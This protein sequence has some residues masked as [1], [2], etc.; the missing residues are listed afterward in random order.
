MRS[1][2]LK[3]YQK[4]ES[5]GLWREAPELQRREVVVAF[6]EASLTLSDP[7]TDSAL[8]HWSL[9]AVER[10]NPGETPALYSP[11]RDALET[12]ELDSSV[13]EAKVDKRELD[14]AKRL[15][16]D[17][18][19]QWKPADYHDAF[20]QTIMDLVEEKASKG[21]IETVE[22]GEAT[23]AGKGADIL[24]LTELL[25]RSLGGKKPAKKTRKAS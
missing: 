7:R 18:S 10:L 9:P 5:P 2:A 14:M 24:D 22:K 15:V 4:L 17:M 6:G 13:T 21:K 1:T 16:E 25:K 19:G 11:G 12:L 8:S 20:R 23:E 3:K